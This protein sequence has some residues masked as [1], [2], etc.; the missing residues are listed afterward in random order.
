M[1][2]QMEVFCNLSRKVA[3]FG[4]I[5]EGISDDDIC[6]DETVGGARASA[7]DPFDDDASSN[8]SSGSDAR[9]ALDYLPD[10]HGGLLSYLLI[11]FNIFDASIQTRHFIY[12]CYFQDPLTILMTRILLL[13]LLHSLLA[14]GAANS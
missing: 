2:N 8:H 11:L 4:E 7:D 13:V 12:L 6:D 9:H 3:G 14:L 5:D 1:V 10:Q